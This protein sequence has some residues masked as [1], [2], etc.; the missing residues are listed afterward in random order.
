[1]NKYISEFFNLKSSGDVLN[2]VYPVL[3]MQKEITESMAVMRHIRKITLKEPMKYTLYD[4]CAGNAL[5]SVIAV[6]LLP[7]KKAIAIDKKVRKRKWHLAK[8]FSYINEDIFSVHPTY[9]EKDAILIGV[10]ACT[11]LTD[12]II[13]LYQQSAA[14]YLI[15]MPCCVGKI[16][17]NY[18]DIIKAKL[19]KYMIWCWQL[20][21][22]CNGRFSIDEHVLSPKNIII[23]AK[24]EG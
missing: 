13:E 14:K 9:F 5:T 21:N 16:K 3:N 12:R 15:L 2:V 18:P 17:I 6:H 10:H 23:T 20:S 1:M 4:L 19:G 7:I 11:N 22:K 8:R 24:K